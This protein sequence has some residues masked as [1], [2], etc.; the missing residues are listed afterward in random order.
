MSQP[1]AAPEPS[2]AQGPPLAIEQSSKRRPFGFIIIALVALLAIIYVVR[3]V[4]YNESHASTDDAYITTDVV[5]VNSLLNGNIVTVPVK[6]NQD[7]KQGDLLAQIDDTTFRADVDQARANLT[8]AIASARSA[9]ADLGLTTETGTAQVNEARGG[10]SAGGAGV[11]TAQAN[12]DKAVSAVATAKATLDASLAQAK[13][14]DDGVQSA[15]QNLALLTQQ[16]SGARDA[17]ANAEAGVKVAQANLVNATATQN[18]AQRDAQ[19]YRSLADQGAVP[20]SEAE[21]KETAAANAA[22]SVDAARQQVSATQA[23]LKQRQSDYAAAG[24]QVN[25]AKTA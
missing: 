10:V 16:L 20:V 17:I 22:A 25:V 21:Q 18:N 1:A 13:A 15:N 11:T 5:P 6:E 24:Q 3:W 8:F 14:A 12:V 23:Q 19:R 9:N 7:V 4:L 2:Q